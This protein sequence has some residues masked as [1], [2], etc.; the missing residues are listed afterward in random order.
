MHTYNA[1]LMNA[2]S[3]ERSEEGMRAA[4]DGFTKTILN[5]ADRPLRSAGSCPSCC[6]QRWTLSVI[7][8]W[9]MTV[10][11]LPHWAS[12]YVDNTC[13]D[14][15][16]VAELFYV[17]SWNL[18]LDETED[19]PFHKCGIIRGERLC[20]KRAGSIQLFWYSTGVWRTDRRTDTGWPH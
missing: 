14:R 2:V 3:S 10:V 20:H 17:E 6:T 11:S 7:N 12:T 8:W 1:R 15:L 9:P 13:D 16:A 5:A 18:V 4:V 19:T